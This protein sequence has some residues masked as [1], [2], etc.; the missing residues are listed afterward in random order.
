MGIAR[1]IKCNNCG[2]EWLRFEGE[3]FIAAYQY[4]D[5]CGKKKVIK[6][7]PGLSQN[8]FN[9]GGKCK[10]GGTFKMDSNVVVCPK[11]HS[12][13]VLQEGDATVLWD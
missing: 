10:C 5:T 11:C 13:E 4:C 9:D 3:G 2:K 12:K 7:L 6:R 8:T 1:N